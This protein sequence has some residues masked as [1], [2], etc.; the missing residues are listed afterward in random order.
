[1]WDEQRRLDKFEN[2]STKGQV[3][4]CCQH[5][6]TALASRTWKPEEGNRDSNDSE[7]ELYS[8]GNLNALKSRILSIVLGREE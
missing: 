8:K 4:M 5:T 3:S 7:V 2:R 6:Q 1:M